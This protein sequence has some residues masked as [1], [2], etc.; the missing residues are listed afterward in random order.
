VVE[1]RPPVKTFKA[2]RD[3]RPIA[4]WIFSGQNHR[5]YLEDSVI[6][7]SVIGQ[8][9]KDLCIRRETLDRAIIELEGLYDSRSILFAAPESVQKTGSGAISNRRGRKSVPPTERNEISQRMKRYWA[10][11]RAGPAD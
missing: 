10:N 1:Q 9:I 7:L 5:Q 11:R 3:L 8:A 4:F 2:Y 6:R